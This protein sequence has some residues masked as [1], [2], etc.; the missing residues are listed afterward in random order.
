MFER[1]MEGQKIEK[2]NWTQYLAPQLTGG[3]HLA[4][5]ALPSKDSGVY[6]T[7]KAAILTRYE[8]HTADGSGQ[9]RGGVAKPI[10]NWLFH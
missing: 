10:V 6:D 7:L 2:A 8:R 3:V 1:M 4:F 5:A 9:Y